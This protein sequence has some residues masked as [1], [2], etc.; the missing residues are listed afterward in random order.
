MALVEKLLIA[1]LVLGVLWLLWTLLSPL[2][3]ARRRPKV[4]D[5]EASGWTRQRRGCRPAA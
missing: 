2:L 4:A 5:D 1:L 3:K